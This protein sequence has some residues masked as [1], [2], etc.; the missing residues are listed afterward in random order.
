ML[1]ELEEELFD[2]CELIYRRGLMRYMTYSESR[3]I[4]PAHWHD[5]GFD[6]RCFGW[7]VLVRK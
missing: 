7:R 1:Y 6:Y 4:V 2:V 3:F 5:D